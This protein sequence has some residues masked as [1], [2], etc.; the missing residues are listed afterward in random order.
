MPIMSKFVTISFVLSTSRHQTIPFNTS[1]SL[2]FCLDG[3]K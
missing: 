3:K 1:M 2:R